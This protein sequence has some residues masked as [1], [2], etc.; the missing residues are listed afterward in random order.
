M[1][2]CSGP[3]AMATIA[4]NA[5]IGR[6]HAAIVGGLLIL[7]AAVY[8]LTRRRCGFPA[9]VLLLFALHPAWT[10]GVRSGDCG[11]LVADSSPY[12]STLAGLILATQSPYTA[13]V[14]IRAAGRDAEGDYDET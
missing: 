9:A 5:E 3:G 14:L 6:Q 7:S 13:W 2:A 12:I 10:I 11:Y 8:L 4:R 1:F